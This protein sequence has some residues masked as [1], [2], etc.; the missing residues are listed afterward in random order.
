[1]T[2]PRDLRAASQPLKKTV[3]AARLVAHSILG[4]YPVPDLSRR[5]ES[6]TRHLLGQLPFFI[7][8]QKTRFAPASHLVVLTGRLPSAPPVYPPTALLQHLPLYTSP[9][10]S[11]PSGSGLPQLSPPHRAA[12]PTGPATVHGVKYEGQCHVLTGRL[13]SAPPVYPPDSNRF[14]AVD[15]SS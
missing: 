14:E 11:A 2:A 3:D 15:P 7:C 5:S 6:P 12:S 10:T 4:F 8:A 1:M 9:P 13:P